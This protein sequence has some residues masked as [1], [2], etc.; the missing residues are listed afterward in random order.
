MLPKGHCWHAAHECFSHISPIFYGRSNF[1][2]IFT[3]FLIFHTFLEDS[4]QLLDI[5]EVIHKNDDP[6]HFSII[7]PS[8]FQHTQIRSMAIVTSEIMQYNKTRHL[9]DLQDGLLCVYTVE[10]CCQ[11]VCSLLT[12]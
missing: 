8:K 12:P 11:T 10:Q 7:Y 5:R 1:L 3:H 2:I 4:L 6:T 9:Q